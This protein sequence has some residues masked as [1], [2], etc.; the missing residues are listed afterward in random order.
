MINGKKKGNALSSL[1]EQETEETFTTRF[2]N[3]FIF[4]NAFLKTSFNHCSALWNQI[5]PDL[6]SIMYKNRT[7]LRT[8]STLLWVTK[9]QR[10][11]TTL[12]DTTLGNTVKFSKTEILHKNVLPVRKEKTKFP[13]SGVDAQNLQNSSVLQVQ[14]SKRGEERV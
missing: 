13:L 7:F 2:Y 10:K 14:M 8:P 5:N 1:A 9:G 11:W 3:I 6:I 4:Q 12:K